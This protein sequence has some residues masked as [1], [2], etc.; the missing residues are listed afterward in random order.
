V[1]VRL[2]DAPTSSVPQRWTVIT[3]RGP[4]IYAEERQ[5]FDEY[6]VDVLLAKDSGGTHTV[7]KLDAADDLGIPVVI[8][9]R[10]DQPPVL[11][12]TTVAEAMAWCHSI[13]SFGDA[14]AS[15][16]SRL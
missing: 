1:L 15:R 9:A 3:S 7:A 14:S 12:A 8:I 16:G 10:P 11:L 4:Y 13:E 5:L 2:V 6:A